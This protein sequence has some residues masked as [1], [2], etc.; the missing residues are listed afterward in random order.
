MSIKSQ[1]FNSGAKIQHPQSVQSPCFNHQSYFPF[2]GSNT[3][4]CKGNDK[5]CI[6]GPVF[7]ARTEAK[8]KK[9]EPFSYIIKT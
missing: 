1:L 7:C 9:K 4:T 6:R 5:D 8:K 2:T 3:V